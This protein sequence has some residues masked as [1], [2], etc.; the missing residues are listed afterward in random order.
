MTAYSTPKDLEDYYKD[1]EAVIDNLSV[2]SPETAKQFT[3]K[4]NRS[5]ESPFKFLYRLAMK[6]VIAKRKRINL[7]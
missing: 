2:S 6:I 5:T 4:L 1:I 3:D 7:P